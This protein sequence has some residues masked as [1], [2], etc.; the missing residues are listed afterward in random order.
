MRPSDPG[1]HAFSAALDRYLTPPDALVDDAA[2]CACCRI[3]STD[4]DAHGLCPSCVEPDEDDRAE[5]LAGSPEPDRAELLAGS[6]EADRDAVIAP[7]DRFEATRAQR[8]TLGGVAVRPLAWTHCGC[9][10]VVF[11]LSLDT[12]GRCP[13]CPPLDALP[14]ACPI[15]VR[16]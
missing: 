14:Y 2:P 12:T 10:R 4:L 9:G 11:Y 1:F 6:P 16:R 7:V 5:L 13:A 8:I 15:E 3:E